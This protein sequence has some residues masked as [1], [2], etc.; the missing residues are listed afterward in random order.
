M[1][2]WLEAHDGTWLNLEKA[3]VFN[4]APMKDSEPGSGKLGVFV[5]YGRTRYTVSVHGSQTAAKSE[6]VSILGG[7]D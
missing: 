1:A 4:V 7:D 2:Y 5:F 6:L 3:H